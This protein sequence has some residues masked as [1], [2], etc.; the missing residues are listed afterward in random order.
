[1]AIRFHR[2]DGT[3][4][5]FTRSVAAASIALVALLAY[6]SV[7]LEAHERLHHDADSPDHHCVISAYAAGEAL[8]LAAT[9]VVPPPVESFTSVQWRSAESLRQP[10]DLVLMPSC[11][12]PPALRFS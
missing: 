12:P 2:R 8:F 1:L 6:L 10:V 11:G 7:D 4:S 3:S 5:I 9:V